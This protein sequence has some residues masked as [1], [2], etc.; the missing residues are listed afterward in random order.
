V[1]NA[2]KSIAHQQQALE[3]V[4]RCFCLAINPQT[5]KQVPFCCFA[6]MIEKTQINLNFFYHKAFVVVEENTFPV[7]LCKF[8]NRVFPCF[9]IMRV[10]VCCCF[11]FLHRKEEKRT[12]HSNT[13]SFS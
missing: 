1:L 12:P 8:M 2:A 6:F 13:N 4:R 5:F 9:L 7:L 11:A 3:E 10:C